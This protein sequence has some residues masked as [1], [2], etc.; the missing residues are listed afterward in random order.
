MRIPQLRLEV[1][2]P[3]TTLRLG[4]CVIDVGAGSRAEGHWLAAPVGGHT[5]SAEPGYVV[6]A[7]HP[8][9]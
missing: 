5:G 6:V 7:P 3:V 1:E 9:G 4:D 2:A 8:Y